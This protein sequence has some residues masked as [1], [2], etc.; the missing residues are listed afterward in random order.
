M[1]T[2]FS[3]MYGDA[4]GDTWNDLSGA[5]YVIGNVYCY[6][7]CGFAICVINNVFIVIVEDGYIRSKFHQGNQWLKEM[8]EGSN[9]SSLD[10]GSFPAQDWI[11]Q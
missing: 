9:S 5:D 4:V 1:F 3:L 6:L 11:N 8:D 10:S 7:W 2:N